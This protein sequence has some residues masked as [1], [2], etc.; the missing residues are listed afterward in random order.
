MLPGFALLLWFIY[1]VSQISTTSRQLWLPQHVQMLYF[2]SS[3]LQ[4]ATQLKYFDQTI[5]K[6]TRHWTKFHGCLS[7]IQ[8]GIQ[9]CEYD[10]CFY[11]G[12]QYILSIKLSRLSVKSKSHSARGFQPFLFWKHSTECH[13]STL[14]LDSLRY[15][16]QK[17]MPLW[18]PCFIWCHFNEHCRTAAPYYSAAMF[19]ALIW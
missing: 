11:L 3:A 19:L 2:S 15:C 18:I 8:Q 16:P 13:L 9:S 1:A 6:L 12:L 5:F 17:N 14:P 7:E 10:G 4:Y